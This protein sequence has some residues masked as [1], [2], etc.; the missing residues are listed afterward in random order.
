MRRLIVP[1][2]ALAVL[3]GCGP[4]EAPLA[5][6][7]VGTWRDEKTGH[8][9]TFTADGYRS[10][11]KGLVSTCWSITGNQLHL[12]APTADSGSSTSDHGD[13]SIYLVAI[14]GETLRI[15][16]TMSPST[17]TRVDADDTLSAEEEESIA[18]IKGK[19][20]KP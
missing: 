3:A 17:H 20:P 9:Q 16:V 5:Q 12:T 4:S 19:C 10:A 14:D 18:K 13:R 11:P 8:T 6:Q 1:M 2:V 15:T 7:I